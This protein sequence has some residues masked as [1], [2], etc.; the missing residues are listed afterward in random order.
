QSGAR[1]IT[2]TMIVTML[3]VTVCE[4]WNQ[5]RFMMPPMISITIKIVTNIRANLDPL[6]SPTPTGC[7]APCGQAHDELG[8]Q[9]LTLLKRFISNDL[10]WNSSQVANRSTRICSTANPRDWFSRR[11]QAAIWVAGYAC[12]FSDAD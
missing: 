8:S 7:G 2:D 5:I 11:I 9:F 6:R 4:V 10:G 3:D 12:S 1:T